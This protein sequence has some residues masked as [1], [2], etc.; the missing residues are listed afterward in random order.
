MKRKLILSAVM[1]VML[2]QFVGCGDVPASEV[3]S[4]MAVEEGSEKET[5]QKAEEK[6]ETA[7]QPAVKAPAEEEEYILPDSDTKKLTESD[8]LP[9]SEEELQL[10]RNEIY[11]RHGRKFETDSIREYFQSKDWY[12]G[13]VE[14]EDFTDNMLSEIELYNAKFIAS[15]EKMLA[16]GGTMETPE[17]KDGQVN[18]SSGGNVGDSLSGNA[19]GEANG[20]GNSASASETV[21]CPACGGL[22]HCK[23]CL[24]GECGTCHG[25][26]QS[27]CDT[28]VGL[29]RCGKCGGSGY[30]YSGVGQMFAKHECPSCRGSGRCRTCGGTAYITCRSCGGSGSC[31]YC[32]GL[33]SCTTCG[34]QGYIY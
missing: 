16:E 20:N 28:C 8:L 33:Y 32:H 3:T 30:Y 17:Q 26:R 12:E 19:I 9:L 25:S 2:F 15:Y 5:T 13:T 27:R 11:A 6:A 14:P 31:G 21:Q 22:G 34:G 29:G 24:Y 10:A 23:Y 4:D 7:K 1:I 18:S